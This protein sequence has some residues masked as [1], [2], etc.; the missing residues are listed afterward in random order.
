MRFPSVGQPVI[1]VAIFAAFGD[2]RLDRRVLAFPGA[3]RLRRLGAQ[4]GPYPGHQCDPLAV[5]KPLE[6]RG[7][8][9]EVRDARRLA[10]IRRN[11]VDL[12]LASS[13]RFAMNA[14]RVPSG[15]QRGLLSLSPGGDT[16]R[17]SAAPGRAAPPAPVG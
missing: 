6:R 14:M 13:L 11:H 1:P 4:V 9:R 3:L 17:A 5:G 10:S 2:M 7:A 15:D 16:P 12:R 8:G